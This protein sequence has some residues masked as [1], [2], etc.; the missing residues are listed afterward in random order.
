[1]SI[2]QCVLAIKLKCATY[3]QLK[4][5]IHSEIIKD[6]IFR[7]QL[8]DY[9]LIFKLRKHNR[10]VCTEI[11]FQQISVYVFNRKHFKICHCDTARN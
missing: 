1:M 7:H 8:D 11:T 2:N 10:L 5:L 6:F 4:T 9:R 3:R